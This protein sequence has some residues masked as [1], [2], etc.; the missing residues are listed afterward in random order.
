MENVKEIP[1]EVFSANYVNEFEKIMEKFPVKNICEVATD[2]LSDSLSD[3][4]NNLSEEEYRVWLDYH[5]KSCER[6]DLIGYSSYILH[7]C[8]KN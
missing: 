6:K 3:Y 8:E 4:I 1:E 5:F 2:G 7:I